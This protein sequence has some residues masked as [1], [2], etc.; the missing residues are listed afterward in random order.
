[1]IEG[2]TEGDQGANKLLE[3]VFVCSQLIAEICIAAVMWIHLQRL[4][5]A[6]GPKIRMRENPEYT[7]LNR[8]LKRC[9]A[10]SASLQ[11]ENGQV[12]GK[13]KT[14]DA[15]EQTLLSQAAGLLAAARIKSLET[16][17]NIQ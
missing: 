8:D 3:N 2:I 6:H 16:H 1:M 13:L 17:Y 4:C 15:L 11:K 5:V 7:V 10:E 12:K 9:I 14:L